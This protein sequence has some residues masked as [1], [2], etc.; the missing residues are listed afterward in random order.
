VQEEVV[1]LDREDGV[2]SRTAV[3]APLADVPG[4]GPKCGLLDLVDLLRVVEPP[5]PA[6][7]AIASLPSSSGSIPV[8]GKI[9]QS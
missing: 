9:R 3:V 4:R 6:R 1:H 7:W 2:A 5:P 8:A